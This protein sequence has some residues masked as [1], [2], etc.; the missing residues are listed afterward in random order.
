MLAVASSKG[1]MRKLKEDLKTVFNIVDPGRVNWLLGIMMTRD[2]G[3]RT[4]SLSKTAYITFIVKQFGLETACPVWTPLDSNVILSKSQ[5]PQ[6]D[7][8]VKD[9]ESIPY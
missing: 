2:H 6:D 5:C 9:M 3:A 7:K 4:I 8:E 1:E